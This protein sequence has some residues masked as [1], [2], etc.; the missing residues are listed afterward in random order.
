M[1]FSHSR[2]T[3]TIFSG[4]ESRQRLG[5]MSLAVTFCSHANDVPVDPIS[6]ER[7]QQIPQ[8]LFRW[9]SP[10]LCRCTME[11]RIKSQKSQIPTKYLGDPFLD[12]ADAHLL[13]RPEDLSWS[14]CCRSRRW[15]SIQRK[16]Y[17]FFSSNSSLFSLKLM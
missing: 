3:R 16:E 15:E 14:P 17:L 13:Q 2:R 12:C 9:P 10:R 1:I 5:E 8:K 11:E 6:R 4:R 7:R